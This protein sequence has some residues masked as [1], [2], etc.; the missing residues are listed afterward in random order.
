MRWARSSEMNFRDKPVTAQVTSL[1]QTLEG[2]THYEY[3]GGMTLREYYAGLAMQALVSN[4]E[5][6]ICTIVCSAV[7]IAD[8]LIA[9][10]E[11]TAR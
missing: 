1:R 2:P 3:E 11:K 4:R 9:E 10:L 6:D 8:A 5:S 7:A